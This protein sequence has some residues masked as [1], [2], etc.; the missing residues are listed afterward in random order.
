[1]IYYAHFMRARGGREND[2]FPGGKAGKGGDADAGRRAK[3]NE[4]S[5]RA[6]ARERLIRIDEA[7]PHGF[8]KGVRTCVGAE[9]EETNSAYPRPQ[10]VSA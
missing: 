6:P 7:R 2:G 3:E 5:L 10:H 1:M 9:T 8:A 4:T